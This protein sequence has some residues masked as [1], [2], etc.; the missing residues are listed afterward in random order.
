[1]ISDELAL[2]GSEIGWRMSDARSEAVSFAHRAH[3]KGK[4][5][6]TEIALVLKVSIQD[7][8]QWLE[9]LR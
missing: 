2:E 7:V 3:Y 8:K 5:T 4:A 9:L 6:P 1:M